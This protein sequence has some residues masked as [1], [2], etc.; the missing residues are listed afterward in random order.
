MVRKVLVAVVATLIVAACG[1]G[2]ARHS[3]K[4]EYGVALRSDARIKV[5]DVSNDSKNLPDVDMIGLLWDSLKE[6]LHKESL[7]WTQDAGG[8]PLLMEAHIT[9]YSKGDDIQRWLL[10]GFGSTVLSVRCEVKDG[11]LLIASVEVKR[12]I[13]YGDGI[14]FRAWKKIFA[15]VAEDAVR[16][17]RSKLRG[18]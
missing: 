2:T 7:L 12:S 6:Q 18:A 14:E 4:L 16:E 3:A 5:V 1:C 17:I 9:K 13:A 8:T 11:D 15:R 10:P